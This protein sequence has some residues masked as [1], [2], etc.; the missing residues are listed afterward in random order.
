MR[1][2]SRNS[3]KRAGARHEQAIADYLAAAFDDDRIERRN[4]N[5]SKDRGDITGVRHAGQRVVIEAKNWSQLH[6]SEWLQEA[7]VE[8]RND[9]ALAGIVVAKRHGKS[10][11]GESVVLM[12]LRDLASLM[13]GR[14]VDDDG[15]D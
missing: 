15:D 11:P 6:P 12:T 13:A 5:G 8:R 14:R 2:R 3:A 9:N 1:G 4:P 7:E 10:D